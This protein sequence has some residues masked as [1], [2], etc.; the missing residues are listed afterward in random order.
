MTLHLVRKFPCSCSACVLL[1]A[2]S[3]KRHLPSPN[4]ERESTDFL[5]P[6]LLR[7]P[8]FIRSCCRE[9][10][11]TGTCRCIRVSE[12]RPV[13]DGLPHSAPRY[14]KREPKRR[15]NGTK[16][17]LCEAVD[18]EREAREYGVHQN[19][20]Q[21]STPGKSPAHVESNVQAG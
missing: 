8:V 10:R 9:P 3:V 19:S 1:A 14:S 18:G 11:C 17:T 20:N 2:R 13:G 15:H 16:L 21:H 5:D 12:S 4:D 7:A 6:A